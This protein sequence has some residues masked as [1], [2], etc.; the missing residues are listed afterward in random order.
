LQYVQ[1]GLEA[2]QAGGILLCAS[3]STCSVEYGLQN[4]QV[5]KQSGGGFHFVSL[6][7]GKHLLDLVGW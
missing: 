2:S 4:G 7:G 6:K 1:Y 5:I 3:L